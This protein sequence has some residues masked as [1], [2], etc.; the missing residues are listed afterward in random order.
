MWSKAPLLMVRVRCGSKGRRFRICLVLALYVVT[1]FLLC[2]EPF[3]RLI[4]GDRGERARAAVEAAL[5]V[6]WAVEGEEPQTYVQVE[7]W[8][9][10]EDVL[11]EVKTL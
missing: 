7:T 3:L 10:D 2:W 9:E 6:L 1:G 8:E 4:P 5:A 11:V